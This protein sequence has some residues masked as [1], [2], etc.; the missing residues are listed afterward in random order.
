VQILDQL[1][2]SSQRFMSRSSMAAA[3][4]QTLRRNARHPFRFHRG[5][6][7]NAAKLQEQFYTGLERSEFIGRAVL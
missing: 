6:Y 3:V 1:T 7:E 2:I 4:K 5:S